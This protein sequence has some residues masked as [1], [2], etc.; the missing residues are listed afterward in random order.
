MKFIYTSCNSIYIYTITWSVN[1]FHYGKK[2]ILIYNQISKNDEELVI[3]F[4]TI[5][6]AFA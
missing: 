6:G 3:F 1:K 5:V 4:D 2:L